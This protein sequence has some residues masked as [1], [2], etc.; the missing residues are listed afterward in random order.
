MAT[1]REFTY[2][3]VVREAKHSDVRAVVRAGDTD[4][5]KFV[6]IDTYGSADREIGDKQ[7]QSIRL[8][9]EAFDFIKLVAERHF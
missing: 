8:T 7:S 6:Q 4:G 3:P 5:E 2:E 9:K 1:I